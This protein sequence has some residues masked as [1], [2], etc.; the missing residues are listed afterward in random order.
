MNSASIGQFL[1]QMPEKI[2]LKITQI[3]NTVLLES[4]GQSLLA[5]GNRKVDW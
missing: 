3:S 2:R 5:R 1:L 4:K